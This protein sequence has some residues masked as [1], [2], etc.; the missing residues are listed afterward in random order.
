MSVVRKTTGQIMTP[1]VRLKLSGF[2]SRILIWA[3]SNP[4][5]SSS[6]KIFTPI[7]SAIMAFV[8]K[9]PLK[10]MK[11]LVLLSFMI[12][13]LSFKSI[14]IFAYIDKITLNG[15]VSFREYTPGFF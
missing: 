5:V 6:E 8:R 2:S 1:A 13:F 10:M 4:I 7:I 15:K 9:I 3:G 12:N 14:S 11:R